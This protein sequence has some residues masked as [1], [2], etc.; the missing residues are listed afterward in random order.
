MYFYYREA[1]KDFIEIVGKN[2]DRFHAGVVNS[3]V[4][5]LSEM[6]ELV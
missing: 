5:T 6:L 3:F 4:G 2:R 1:G